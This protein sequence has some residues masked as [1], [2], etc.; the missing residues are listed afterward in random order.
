MAETCYEKLKLALSLDEGGQ[1][2]AAITA[3]SEAVQSILNLAD[4]DQKEKLK[5]FAIDA[6]ERAEKLKLEMNPEKHAARTEEA[7]KAQKFLKL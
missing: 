1:K 4:G 5:K 3:Y 6:L 2:A 7:G